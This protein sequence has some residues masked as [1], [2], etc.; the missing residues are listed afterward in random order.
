MA[1][2]SPEKCDSM[3]WF[4]ENS[5]ELLK[6][7]VKNKFYMLFFFLDTYSRGKQNYAQSAQMKSH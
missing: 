1:G 7:L 4:L 3:D 5:F 6:A 2:F